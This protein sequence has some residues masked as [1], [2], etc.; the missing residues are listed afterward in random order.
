MQFCHNGRNYCH[1]TLKSC[2]EKK[3]RGWQKNPFAQTNKLHA[4]AV[5]LFPTSKTNCPKDKNKI[6]LGESM[7]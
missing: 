3:T 7:S 2:C 5:K 1:E 6:V 4:K